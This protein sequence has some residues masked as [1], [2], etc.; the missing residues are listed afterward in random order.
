MVDHDSLTTMMVNSI[1]VDQG[2]VGIYSKLPDGQMTDPNLKW[3]ELIIQKKERS[4]NKIKVSKKDLNNVQKLN[5][6]LK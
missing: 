3:I 2:I 6:I 5:Q 4:E 1:V